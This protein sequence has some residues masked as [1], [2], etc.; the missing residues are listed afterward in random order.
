MIR[1]VSSCHCLSDAPF[2]ARPFPAV[3]QHSFPAASA[4][5]LG[6]IV[7]L[8]GVNTSP[9]DRTLGSVRFA[10]THLSQPLPGRTSHSSQAVTP[11][12]TMFQSPRQ[13]RL[14]AHSFPSMVL[15]LLEVCQSFLR[16]CICFNVAVGLSFSFVL[17]MFVNVT[18]RFC[19]LQRLAECLYSHI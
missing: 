2:S 1:L 7:R 17:R 16:H 11:L 6:P 5:L 4:P 10:S 12:L 8:N 9:P 3:R 15:F 18:V 13:G 14:P 19:G